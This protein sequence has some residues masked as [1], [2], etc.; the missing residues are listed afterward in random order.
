VQ[1]AFQVIALFPPPAPRPGV[2]ARANGACTGFAADRGV[3]MIV[4]RV[5]RNAQG[6]HGI[7]DL[8]A[9][10]LGQ[11]IEFAQA[12]GLVELG[13]WQ[14]GTRRRLLAALACDPCG[15]TRQRTA[16]W[17]DLADMAGSLA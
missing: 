11:G 2:L 12:E 6:A 3:A 9:R 1:A 13:L 17:L 7:P 5:V 4:Q 14:L 16:Q 15:M 8:I 10:P